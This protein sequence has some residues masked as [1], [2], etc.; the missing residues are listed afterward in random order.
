MLGRLS[1]CRRS[2]FEPDVRLKPDATCHP[3]LRRQLVA[4]RWF[5]SHTHKRDSA[6]RSKAVDLEEYCARIGYPPAPDDPR[7][8]PRPEEWRGCQHPRSMCR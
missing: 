7:P 6:R 4:A 8:T 2:G 3:F 1:G 5:L